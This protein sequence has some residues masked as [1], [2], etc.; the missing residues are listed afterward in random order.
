MLIRYGAHKSGRVSCSHCHNMY[1]LF[2]LYVEHWLVYSF[3]WKL[4]GILQ[5]DSCDNLIQDLPHVFMLCI[6]AINIF[7]I[8]IWIWILWL[9]LRFTDCTA[10]QLEKPRLSW[11]APVSLSGWYLL[12]V[13]WWCMQWPAIPLYLRT[14]VTG[15]YHPFYP[16]S[17]WLLR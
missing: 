13:V 5:C 3:C 10:E 12:R 2:L 15:V 11:L 8:W 7:W 6:M 9:V 17:L 14:D 16:C 4:S 1:Y